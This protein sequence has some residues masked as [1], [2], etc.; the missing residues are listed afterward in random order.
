MANATEIAEI[1]RKLR[2]LEAGQQ[3]LQA[4][5]AEMKDLFARAVVAQ[6]STWAGHHG[7]IRLNFRGAELHV[8][9]DYGGKSASFAEFSF[10]F[11]SY[12]TAL[13]PTGWGG[14]LVKR[15]GELDRA[16]WDTEFWHV[17]PL[18]AALASCL[19]T[20]MTGEV[21]TLV[22]RTL[23]AEPSASFRAWQ[24]L[25]RWFRPKSVIE[26]SASMARIMEPTKCKTLADLQRA[27]KG[28]IPTRTWARVGAYVGKK[29][30]CSQSKS[31][32]RWTSGSVMT[33]LTQCTPGRKDRH[34]ARH[35]RA[36]SSSSTHRGRGLPIPARNASQTTRTRRTL[37]TDGRPR[38]RIW[39]AALAA[40]EGHPARLCPSFSATAVSDEDVGEEDE[41]ERVRGAL[42]WRR[43]GGLS[44]HGLRSLPGTTHATVKSGIASPPLSIQE[45]AEN[46]LPPD[47][48]SHIKPT[49]TDK[50]RAGIGFRGAGEGRDKIQNFW[51]A[52]IPGQGQRRDGL[53]QHLAGGR[54]KALRSGASVRCS[55]R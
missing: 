12:M 27:V 23:W 51:E 46:V 53:Q 33:L 52:G 9:K 50:S 35:S 32:H 2:E 24:E 38:R 31:Q 43:L 48:C 42:L 5:H 45:P 15:A 40:A 29:S 4:T 13:Y 19:I 49:P 41:E 3:Q 10:E 34:Q 6:G 44:R 8:P 28:R 30:S 22:R 11:E 14:A 39:F 25:A 54:R 26:G 16:E 21:S 1:V 18:G 36:S 17:N 47:A 20:A 7:H 55:L 37:T